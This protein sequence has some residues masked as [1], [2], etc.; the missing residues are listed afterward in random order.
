MAE[1]VKAIGMSE[2]TRPI[3]VGL[4]VVG[5]F[6]AAWAVVAAVAISS[7]TYSP[8]E[9]G[10]DIFGRRSR[11]EAVPTASRC[12]LEAAADSGRLGGEQALAAPSPGSRLSKRAVAPQAK[13]ALA[14]FGA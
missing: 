7:A 6:F 1:A 2:T 14:S 8:P 3:T 13:N 4:F 12:I 5:L 9:M 10:A 11:I